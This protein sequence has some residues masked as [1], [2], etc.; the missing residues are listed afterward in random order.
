MKLNRTLLAATLI[1]SQ[2]TWAEEAPAPFED[3]NAKFQSTYIWQKKSALTAPYTGPF[4]L[5]PQAEKTYTFTFTGAFGKRLWEGAE[6]YFDPEIT[7]GVPLSNLTGLAGF[8]NGEITRASGPKPIAYRVRMFVRQTINL[9]GGEEEVASGMNQLAGSV[10]KE[11]L[12]VTA[13]F[14]PPLDIFDSN[15][16]AHDPR[17][18]FMSWCNMTHCAFDYAA[19]ARGNTWGVALEYYRPDWVFRVGQYMQPLIANQLPV[20]WKFFRHHGQNVEIE[21]AHTLNDQPGKFRLQAYRNTAKAGSF[22]DAMANP[23]LFASANAGGFAAT[24]L[25]QRE[26]VK[27]GFGFNLEQALTPAVGLFARAMWQDGR[28]ETYAFTEAHRSGALGLSVNGSLWGREQDTLGIAT[29][30]N[31]LSGVYRQYLSAGGLGYFIGDGKLNYADEQ[32]VESYY[33]LNLWQKTWL[34]LDYQYVQN[35]AYNADRG[36]VNILGGRMHWEY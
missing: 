8:Y 9:G 32:I 26:G 33:S 7:Q 3:W 15:R 6:G 16:Y 34:T 20:D 17:T 18:Q 14:M 27:Y 4:S 5:V 13:G 19:D 12:V 25:V 28:Y 23:G 35:P 31:A 24:S 22:A 1:A 2:S 29:M 36:P 21:H 11:R 10:D 30:R